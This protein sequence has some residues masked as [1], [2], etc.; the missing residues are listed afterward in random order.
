MSKTISYKGTLAIGLQDRIKLS[1]IQGKVGYRITKFQLFPT[2]PHTV[3]VALVCKIF[4]KDQTGSIS[5]TVDFTDSDLMGVAAYED[6]ASSDKVTH[7]TILFDNE[8]TNQDIFITMADADSNT[9]PANYYIELETM[10]LNDIESTMLT[11]KSLR[12]IASR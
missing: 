2:S 8:I 5:P 4:K 10:S 6:K 1:T 7:E 11:L 3:D 9:T 12:T